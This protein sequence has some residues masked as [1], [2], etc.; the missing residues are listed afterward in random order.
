MKIIKTFNELEEV[1]KKYKCYAT[2][3]DGTIIDSMPMWESFASRYIL[4]KGLKPKD[5]LDQKIKYLSNYDAA[6]I[7]FNDYHV[8]ES[9]DKIYDDI[10]EFVIELYPTINFK[11]GSP[12]L[13]ELLDNNGKNLLS[14]ATPEFM[15]RLST[16]ALNITNKYKNIY[17]SS[18]LHKS[19]ESGELFSFILEKEK[20]NNKELLVIEDSILAMK[21]CKKMGIDTL[22]ILDY[23]NKDDFE[24]IAKDGT[25]F[26][27]LSMLI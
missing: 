18:D 24:L 23:S 10:N 8:L 13:L 16:D 22:M 21:A 20:I 11:D 17:S 4:S 25:Y 2:D 6:K 27:D 1:L 14:S 12:K 15:L 26:V 3:Y 9:I 5:D 19:K 7:I